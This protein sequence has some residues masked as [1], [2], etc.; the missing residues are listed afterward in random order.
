MGGFDLFQS[1]GNF[2]NWSQPQNLGY[3]VNSVK[4]DL[5][6]I[7]RG[8]NKDIL[9]DVLSQECSGLP[10]NQRRK[11]SHEIVLGFL[12]GNKYDDFCPRN[13]W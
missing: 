3:P 12:L 13:V 4:D 10:G 5:Y 7:S 1:N 8:D 9:A 11:G 6:I 2:G